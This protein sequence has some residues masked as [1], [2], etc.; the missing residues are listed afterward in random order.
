MKS[1]VTCINVP[2]PQVFLQRPGKSTCPLSPPTLPGRP[3]A[4]HR[5]GCGGPRP[6]PPPNLL[7]R[8]VRSLL[9]CSASPPHVTFTPLPPHLRYPEALARRGEPTSSCHPLAAEVPRERDR[10]LGTRP[11]EPG[12]AS[13]SWLSPEAGVGWRVWGGVAGICGLE[14]ATS[15]A[16]LAGPPFG[17]LA[18]CSRLCARARSPPRALLSGFAVVLAL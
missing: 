15:C 18:G 4:R 9:H 10:A 6:L 17:C 14:R 7:P 2:G 5:L 1:P 11:Q 8:W 16:P 3:T 12:H 13:Q